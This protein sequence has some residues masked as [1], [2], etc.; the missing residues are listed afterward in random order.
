MVTLTW[1]RSCCSPHDTL[2]DNLG[3]NQRPTL[4]NLVMPEFLADRSNWP[5]I[6][7]SSS[8]WVHRD[9]FI[10]RK[11]TRP[12]RHRFIKRPFKYRRVCRCKQSRRN[13]PSRKCLSLSFFIFVLRCPGLRQAG[14]DENGGK[15]EGW[16]GPENVT[17]HLNRGNSFRSATTNEMALLDTDSSFW[18]WIYWNWKLPSARCYDSKEKQ[19]IKTVW[20]SIIF[21]WATPTEQKVI[22]SFIA[23]ITSEEHEKDVCKKMASNIRT[24]WSGNEK[25][26]EVL[27]LPIAPI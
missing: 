25:Q 20:L 9:P 27:H 4:W 11:W 13:A 18:G 8:F 15:S 6:F 17:G 21:I 10:R 1:S 23:Y 12:S 16:F 5:I 26:F 22:F 24:V 19:I 3:L 14:F 7:E 2:K